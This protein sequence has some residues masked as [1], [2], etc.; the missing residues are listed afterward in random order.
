MAEREHRGSSRGEAGFTL[1]EVITVT[2]VLSIVLAVTVGVLWSV[3]SGVSKATSRSQSNDSV[4]LAVQELDRQI[5][6]G[7]VLYDPAS[8]NDPAN[9]IRPGL[10]LRIYTQ[11][12]APTNN[13]ANRC[14]QW[15]VHQG[16]LQVRSW[17]TAW[18]TDGVVSGWRTV[19]GDMV[20]D[21]T[22]PAF[23]LD[24]SEVLFGERVMRVSLVS[25]A[26]TEAGEPVRIDA[27]ITGRNTQYEFPRAVCADVPPYP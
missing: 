15:R 22:T 1:V 25:N 13:P 5:R 18:R 27:S 3:Q 23:A 20:N 11:A 8:E 19:V 14:V 4:R 10:S 12:N 7:N 21:S 24:R 9:G 17:S 6:S 26:K 16:K 2:A